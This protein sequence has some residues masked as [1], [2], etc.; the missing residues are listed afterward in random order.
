VPSREPRDPFRASLRASQ[1]RRIA[2]VRTR[3]RRLRGRTGATVALLSR[4]LL[5]GGAVAAPPASTGGADTVASRATGDTIRQLQTKLGV[6]ADGVLGP[7]TRAAVKR[8]QR[9]S[10]LPVDGVAGPA[11]LAAL[12]IT[13]SAPAPTARAASAQAAAPDASDGTG[14]SDALLARIAQCE[15][16]GDPTAV[17]ADGVYRGKYQ[18]S[19]STWKAM[20]GSGDPAAAPEA[21]QDQRAELLLQ[22]QGRS[23]WPVCGAA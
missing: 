9:R 14:T 1:Q 4:T 20:G 11:T 3:R 2:A 7:Q 12:G 21:E 13:A 10:G 22:R 18:F 6:T 23:A 16:S 8:F 5:A 17:S 15:S 19:R